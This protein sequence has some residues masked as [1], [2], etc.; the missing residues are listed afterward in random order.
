MTY[1]CSECGETHDELPRFFMRKRP[2]REDGSV[3]EATHDHKSMCSTEN[4]AFV[5]CE[6]EIPVIG[7]PATPLGFICWVEVDELDYERILAFRKDEE[8]GQ[9]FKELV[10]GRLANPVTG[11][12]E[13]FGTFAKFDVLEEDPTPYVRWIAPGTTLAELVE[14][15]ATQAFWH[16]LV[17][18]RTH[19]TE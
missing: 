2:E 5:R 14:T 15:G 9:P 10:S 3:I 19:P 17:S 12:P 7:V 18:G 8:P 1:K 6:I 4:Q 11:V 16:S 13:T